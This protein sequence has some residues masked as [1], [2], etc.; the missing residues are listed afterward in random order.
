MLLIS[1]TFIS[2]T[3]YQT[4]CKLINIKRIKLI[5]L[6]SNF[7]FHCRLDQFGPAGSICSTADDMSNV[8]NFLT[9]PQ[10]FDHL[11]IDKNVFDGLF[12][13][14]SILPDSVSSRYSLSSPTFP[15]ELHVFGYGMAW[16]LA[17]YRGKKC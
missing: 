17:K 13:Q 5:F 2:I 11:S 12:N 7:E 16:F 8:L 3:L 15:V 6:F 4:A 10:D 1:F 14:K 9:S